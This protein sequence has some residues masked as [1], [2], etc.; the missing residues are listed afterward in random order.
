MAFFTGLVILSLLS[1]T[2]SNIIYYQPEAIHLAYGDNIHDIVVTWTTRN[3]TQES[4][5]E[6]GIEELIFTA[7]GNS[8]LFVD[9]GNE[10]QKQYIHRVWLRNLTPSTKYIYHCGSKYGWSNVFHLKTVPDESTE[11]SPRIVVFGDMG[12]E[13]AQSLS[14]LQEEAQRGLYDV[15]IHIGDF[16]YDMNTDNARVGDE[17]MKQIEGVAAYL[18]YMTVAGNHEEKYNFSNYRSRFT[19][20]GDS[21][22]LWYSFNI[23]PIHFIAIE[24]EAYYFMNYGIKQVVKQ[25][26]WLEKDL[27]EANMPEN[28]PMYCSNANLD[29]CTSHADLVRVGLPV[30]NW[31]GLENLF[32]KYKV[33]LLLWAHEH[34][35]ERLWPIYENPYKNYGAPVHVVT[36]SAGCKEGREKFVPHRPEWSAYRNSDYG[37]TRM[38]AYN[39]THLYLEQVSDDKGG[40]VLDH[41]WLVKDD[42]LPAYNELRLPC[43]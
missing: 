37:Y 16:A 39:Q 36:G 6:Y 26:Q 24:T 31:F 23:G 29:D 21:E 40:A 30:L 5:V 7:T 20:P 25:Y 35:Y 34:S 14:R 32:Y 43:K 17:F 3:D 15:A 41:V 11:W 22:G 13:N 33:D 2:L 12:N 19:M 4:I 9:G 1:V 10:K 42:I 18:P 8:T 28:R 27:I 38:K